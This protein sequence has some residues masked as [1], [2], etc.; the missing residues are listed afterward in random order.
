MHS[1]LDRA[2]QPT[3]GTSISSSRPWTVP[4]S[5]FLPWRMG[6]AASNPSL[7]PD[8]SSHSSRR[9]PRSRDRAQ[10]TQSGRDAQSPV[11]KPDRGPPYRSQRPSRVMPTV[12][13]VNRLRSRWLSTPWADCRDTSYSV[14]HPPNSTKIVCIKSTS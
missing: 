10:G 9:S 7:L 5:P 6:N 13:G 4:S 8:P 11:S 3:T 14:E 2:P 1:A 12:R